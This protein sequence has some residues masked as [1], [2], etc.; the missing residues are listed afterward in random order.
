VWPST[1]AGVGTWARAGRQ[2]SNARKQRMQDGMSRDGDIDS[3]GFHMRIAV[4]AT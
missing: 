4:T 3:P 1:D 2:Q